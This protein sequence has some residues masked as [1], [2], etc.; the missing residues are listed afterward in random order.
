MKKAAL[1]ALASIAAVT[2]ASD[3][4]LNIK[5]TGREI[6]AD[7]SKVEHFNQQGLLVV[8]DLNT[9]T[10]VYSGIMYLLDTSKS[11]KMKIDNKNVKVRYYDTQDVDVRMITNRFRQLGLLVEF[12]DTQLGGI[13]RVQYGSNDDLKFLNISAG[14]GAFVST[15]FSADETGTNQTVAVEAP[16]E[17]LELETGKFAARLNR[18]LTEAAGTNGVAA[19]EEWLEDGNYVHEEMKTSTGNGNAYGKNK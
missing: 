7:G 13:G 9:E 14:H 16:D 6:A 17:L 5:I 1:I 4:V 10:N 11:G 2:Y 3:A 12:E 15:A 19:V 18:K 8:R